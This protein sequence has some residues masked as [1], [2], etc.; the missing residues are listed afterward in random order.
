MFIEIFLQLLF[1]YVKGQKVNTDEDG[2]PW[3][4]ERKT[5]GPKCVMTALFDAMCMCVVQIQSF[6]AAYSI[7][8]N[9]KML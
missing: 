6:T 5:R 4:L 9:I 8:S 2:S 1:M 7:L 3:R